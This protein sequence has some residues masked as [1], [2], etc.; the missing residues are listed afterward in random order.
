MFYCNNSGSNE[1]PPPLSRVRMHRCNSSKNIYVFLKIA[2]FHVFNSI[3][4]PSFTVR[5]AKGKCFKR[6]YR[7]APWPMVDSSSKNIFLP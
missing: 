7:G 2:T 3:D 4:F 5:P 1:S 6:L